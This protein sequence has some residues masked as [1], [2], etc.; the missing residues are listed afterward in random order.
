VRMAG[1]AGGPLKS[2]SEAPA[3]F[4]SIADEYARFR[5]A[6]PSE[7]FDAIWSRLMVSPPRVID[8]AAGTGAATGPLVERGG[9]VVAV[10]PS[11]TMLVHARERVSSRWT[12]GL[13]AL[14]EALPFRDRAVDLVTVGQALHWFEP[15]RALQEIAQVLAP[16]GIFAVFWNITLGD[17]FGLEVVHLV[18]RWNPR[19]KRPVTQKMRA[20][21]PALVDHPAFD[22]EPPI[23]IF[24]ARPMDADRYVGY[25]LSWSYAGGALGADERAPFE[26]ELRALIVRHHGAE[27]WQERFVA[28]LHLARRR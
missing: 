20:T 22:L 26:R 6:Y 11:A 19:H 14:A 3:I 17:E 2:L 24:H 8:L 27:S 4:G 5:P 1:L 25:V 16:G 23:E 15:E 12:G 7:L 10:E 28:S 13:A 18:D 9:R 21:P